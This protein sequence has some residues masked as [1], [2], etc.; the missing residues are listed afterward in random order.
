L[1]NLHF[2]MVIYFQGQ[3]DL[4]KKLLKSALRIIMY[5][6]KNSEELAKAGELEGIIQNKLLNLTTKSINYGKDN[7][8]KFSEQ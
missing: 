6:E 8:K 3:M 7:D 4:V 5:C 1:L 2:I